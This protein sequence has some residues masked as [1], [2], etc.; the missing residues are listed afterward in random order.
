MRPKDCTYAASTGFIAAFPIFNQIDVGMNLSLIWVAVLMAPLV[1]GLRPIAWPMVPLLVL[2]GIFMLKFAAVAN[3]EAALRY[4]IYI[5]FIMAAM[6]GLDRRRMDD[7]FRGFEIG[8]ICNIAFGCIQMAGLLT[9]TFEAIFPVTAWNA[10]LWHY[11]PPG[12]M[13]LFYP[14]VSGFCNEPAYLGTLLI[15][16]AA[17]RVFVQGRRT[18][19]GRYGVY[20]FMSIVLLV[21]S[22][23]AF[24]S[25]LWLAGCALVL[26]FR[27][28]MV[29]SAFPHSRYRRQP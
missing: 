3:V 16:Q 14:R 13:F 17:Y 12:G 28:E 7:F 9:G 11:N 25:Y 19:T 10:T 4:A 24:A 5:G 29:P 20:L 15:A 2:L 27:W 26:R 22:R 8:L 1:Y 6:S 23:T 18:L 21:N